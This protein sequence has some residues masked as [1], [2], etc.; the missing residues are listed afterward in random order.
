MF[1]LVCQ[2]VVLLMLSRFLPKGDFGDLMT[3]F[4]FYRLTGLALGVGGDHAAEIRLQR[5][6]ALIGASQSCRRKRE[7]RRVSLADGQAAACGRRGR[8]SK[9]GKLAVTA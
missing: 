7:V 8:G 3:A 4:G 1:G 6:L 5:F 2:F 9:P